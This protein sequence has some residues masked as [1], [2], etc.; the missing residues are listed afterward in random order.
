MQAKLPDVN[1][2]LVTHRKS[3]LNAYDMGDYAK[4]AIAFQAII[5]LLPDDYKVEINTL[6]YNELVK[7][8]KKMICEECTEAFERSL[9]HPYELTLSSLDAL[10]LQMPKTLVW[11]CPKCHATRPMDGSKTQTIL[12]QAPY[13]LKVVPE[14]PTRIGLE[15][16]IGF[17]YRCRK[18]FDIVF[19]EIENQIGR[20]RADYAAQQEEEE[21]V[22][23]QDGDKIE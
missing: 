4:A 1:A 19:K 23:D 3:A 12:F 15:A 22:N 6:R 5:A 13:Y 21:F 7:K 10:I 20:Y 8:K 16:R 11:D 2:A 14:A 18:W 9:I 17:Q